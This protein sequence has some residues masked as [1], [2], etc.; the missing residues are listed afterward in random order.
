MGFLMS[1]PSNHQLT[2]QLKELFKKRFYYSL[3]ELATITGYSPDYIRKKMQYFEFSLIYLFKKKL[4]NK[5][6]VYI[7]YRDK[8]NL[9]IIEGWYE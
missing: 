3:D 4:K 9:K 8:K 1:N 2:Y 6:M 5:K 7:Y